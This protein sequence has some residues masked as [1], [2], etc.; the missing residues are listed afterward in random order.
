MF[1]WQGREGLVANEVRQ[2][3]HETDSV[4]LAHLGKVQMSIEQLI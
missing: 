4:L 2:R 1:P 3:K